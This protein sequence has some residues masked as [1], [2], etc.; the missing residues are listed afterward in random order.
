MSQLREQYLQAC[1]DLRSF[2]ESLPSYTKDDAF[3]GAFKF[4][5]DKKEDVEE[6]IRLQ[7]RHKELGELLRK[8][9]P[10]EYLDGTKDHFN[11]FVTKYKDEELTMSMTF[12]GET[13]SYAIL[14]ENLIEATNEDIDVIKE[15]A[16][17]LLFQFIANDEQ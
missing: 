4:S 9:N 17:H 3:E 5:F 11:S 14:L 12:K 16:D 2:I 10:T 15:I 1:K 13:I 8:E 6:Y 7:K